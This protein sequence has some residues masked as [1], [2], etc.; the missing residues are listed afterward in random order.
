MSIRK[1]LRTNLIKI[2]ITSSCGEMNPSAT[3]TN[4]GIGPYFS[5]CSIFTAR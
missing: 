2:C 4:N 3:K 1:I 5:K